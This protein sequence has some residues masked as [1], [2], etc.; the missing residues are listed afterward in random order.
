M[1]FRNLKPKVEDADK[2]RRELEYA[3]ELVRNNPLVA[4]CE[5]VLWEDV[6]AM[7]ESELN[8]VMVRQNAH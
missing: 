6:E 7:A 1:E 5:P 3:L 4:F 2:S 8:K